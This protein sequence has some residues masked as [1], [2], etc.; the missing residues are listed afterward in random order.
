[1]G[2]ILS[3]LESMGL[4]NLSSVDLFHDKKE[5]KKKEA[6]VNKE[7]ERKPEEKDFIFEKDMDCACCGHRFKEKALRPNRM[8]PKAQDMDLRPRYEELD[9]LK[10]TISVCPLCG[11]AALSKEFQHLSQAQAR[12]IKEKISINFTGIKYEGDVYSY[13]DAIARNKLALVNSIVKHGKISE[14]AYICLNLGWLTRGKADSLDIEGPEKK[15]ILEILSNEEN[16]YLTKAAEGFGEALMKESFPICGMNESTFIY[17]LSAL[18]YET[19][20]YTEA[21]KFAERILMNRAIS[22]RIK[23]KAL[24]IK[25]AIFEIKNSRGQ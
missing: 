17:L 22:D 15:K 8:K 21:L 12:F 1:M 13:D 25:E 6:V 19:G 5:E 24:K 20:R 10:Y 16:D 4:G 23:D 3:G 7:P 2:D 9:T 11:Y 14:R 18:N